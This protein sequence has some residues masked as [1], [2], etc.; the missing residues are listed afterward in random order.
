[1]KKIIITFA[2]AIFSVCTFSQTMSF[3]PL[4]MKILSLPVP[5]ADSTE[6][7]FKCQAWYGVKDNPYTIKV[8]PDYRWAQW[9]NI[10]VVSSTTYSDTIISI[11]L[12]SANAYRQRVYPD[13]Q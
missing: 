5:N 1:M 12:D 3:E 6:W 11:S 8:G 7:T 10:D 13:I 4:D 9:V 2:F